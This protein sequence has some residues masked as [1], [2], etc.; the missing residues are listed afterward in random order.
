[1]ANASVR[2]PRLA[3]RLDEI[4]GDSRADIL[5]SMLIVRMNKSHAAWTQT[6][7]GFIDP[8]LD[9][10]PNEPHL[11]VHV[12]VQARGAMPAAA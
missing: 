4:P 3:P 11:R 1:M 12:T 9:R 6:I 7:A 2:R 10:L 8:E 5:G